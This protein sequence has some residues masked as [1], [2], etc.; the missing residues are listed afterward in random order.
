MG[1]KKVARGDLKIL[2]K[3]QDSVSMSWVAEWKRKARKLFRSGARFQFTLFPA[4][5]DLAVSSLPKQP[6][7]F[8]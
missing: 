5:D 1:M 8:Q 2:A 3:L 7:K 6:G 4:D